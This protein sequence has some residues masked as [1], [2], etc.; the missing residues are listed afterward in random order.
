ML[1]PDL[2]DLL[3]RCRRRDPAAQRALYARFADSMMSVCLRYTRSIPEA[4]DIL[5][6]AFVKVFHHLDAFRGEGSLEGW[7]RRIVVST[8]IDAW[9][10]QKKHRTDVDID[11]ARSLSAPDA[12]AL[13]RIGVDE[14]MLLI[15]RLPEGCRMVLIM[16][17][18][19]GYT[20]AE[21]GHLL[22]ITESTSKAQLSKARQRL[23]N[24]MRDYEREARPH[25][26][27]DD[28]ATLLPTP[29]SAPST[30]SVSPPSRSDAP[31]FQFSP[32]LG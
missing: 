6:D 18:I 11:D 29:Y 26:A 22:G 30:A 12:D 32:A 28:P 25:P 13:Q 20:H 23:V 1:A 8:A 9:H 19:D 16:Y 7:I 5:Q 15:Q 10:K 27:P 24:L 3:A 14:V 2:L 31:P 21:I 17:T 4:E